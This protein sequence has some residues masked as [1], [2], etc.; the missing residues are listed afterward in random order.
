M[1][2][3]SLCS[4]CKFHMKLGWYFPSR[5]RTS[6]FRG[7][8]TTDAHRVAAAEKRN[9]KRNVPKELSGNYRKPAPLNGRDTPTAQ[10]A[11]TSHTQPL[12]NGAQLG[13]QAQNE[14]QGR[15]LDKAME[16]DTT[17][18]PDINLGRERRHV[19]Q[20]EAGAHAAE[21]AATQP[22][23]NV[24]EQG[25]NAS[26]AGQHPPAFPDPASKAAGSWLAKATAEVAAARTR[27]AHDQHGAHA[28]QPPPA[29]AA[30]AEPRRGKDAAAAT[31][32][33]APDQAP[34]AAIPMSHPAGEPQQLHP[35]P[36]QSTPKAARTIRPSSRYLHWQAAQFAACTL[37]KNQKRSFCDF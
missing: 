14:E 16:C 22:R 33:R 15:G 30:A 36:L 21:T 20:A 24:N 8:N 10:D 32:L 7:L 12:H 29:I 26:A 25:A 6:V 31:P 9:G 1:T 23:G 18:T 35:G 27:E 11:G 28:K 19:R 17:K 3:A 2:W 34:A 4:L 37:I 5:S 13:K